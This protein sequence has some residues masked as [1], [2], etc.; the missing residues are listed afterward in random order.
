MASLTKLMRSTGLLL[1]LS[2]LLCIPSGQFS[3]SFIK[4]SY[5]KI[6]LSYMKEIIFVTGN[7]KKADYLRELLEYPL[8]HQKLDLDEIQ[9]LDLKKVVEHKLH[10]A[11]ERVQKP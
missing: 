3:M 8:T 2:P 10:Q 9:S 1:I 6:R 4:K 5:G 7:Q 11:Y